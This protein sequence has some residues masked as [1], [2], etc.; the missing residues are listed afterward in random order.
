MYTIIEWASDE[1]WTKFAPNNLYVRT[2]ERSLT[3]VKLYIFPVTPDHHDNCQVHRVTD[4]NRYCHRIVAQWCRIQYGT[5]LIE[6]ERCKKLCIKNDLFS[7][8]LKWKHTFQLR[9]KLLSTN[10][11]LAIKLDLV[12]FTN[13]YELAFINGVDRPHRIP[14]PTARRCPTWWLLLLLVFQKETNVRNNT[15]TDHGRMY[16]WSR[17]NWSIMR[18]IYLWL[19]AFNVCIVGAQRRSG[20]C[21]SFQCYPIADWATHGI[22][23]N[24]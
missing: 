11:T 22:N 13:W 16:N 23:M 12:P 10:K 8:S 1:A 15:E 21:F 6:S 14:P 9:S 5:E 3:K 20:K 19:P 7:S 2:I 24:D 17:L 4:W 18:H